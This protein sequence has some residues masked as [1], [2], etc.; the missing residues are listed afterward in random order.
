MIAVNDSAINLAWA[1]DRSGYAAEAA[2]VGG[3]DH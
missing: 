1:R 2:P 3:H